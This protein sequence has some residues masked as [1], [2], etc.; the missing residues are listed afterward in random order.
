MEVTIKN[1]TGSDINWVVVEGSIEG[2]PQVT[3]RRSIH[4]AA[5]ASGQLTIASE[6]ATLK[7]AVSRGLT[8]WQAAQAAIA[9]I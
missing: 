6:I 2:F 9:Q 5:L 1:V 7:E 3:Q 8:H 4:A